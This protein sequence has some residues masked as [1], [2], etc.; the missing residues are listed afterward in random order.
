[1]Q[2]KRSIDGLMLVFIGL[3]IEMFVSVA[4][5]F[6]GGNFAFGTVV[7]W[8]NVG[9]FVVG[10]IGLLEL[11]KVN[12]NFAKTKILYIIYLCIMVGTTI[13]T[14]ILSGVSTGALLKGSI[15][16][17]IAILI[18]YLIRV[19][20]LFVIDIM[21][22][23]TLMSGC[24]DVAKDNNNDEYARSCIS[25]WRLYLISMIIHTILM[26]IVY[27]VAMATA[28]SVYSLN[29]AAA[30]GSAIA[31]V[32][33]SVFA[34]IAAIFVLIT[35]IRIMAKVYGTYS[36]FKDG[37]ISSF[38]GSNAEVFND[39]KDDHKDF[40]Q[41]IRDS[42]TNARSDIKESFDDIT[43]NNKDSSSETSNNDND[44]SAKNDNNN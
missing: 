30:F 29:A 39:M 40:R 16:P 14:S 15:G 6:S 36:R 1:M 35:I 28:G 21:R 3:V 18:I 26:V 17:I 27:I 25:T 20:I 8:I 24:H 23:K 4:L 34:V 19:I 42:V 12:L 2:N 33:V 32:V 9:A 41:D 43:G 5:S 22:V 44:N 31:L 7:N 13:I 10:L 38:S 11:S 37:N